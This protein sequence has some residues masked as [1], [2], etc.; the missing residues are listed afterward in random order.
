MSGFIGKGDL[1]DGEPAGVGEGRCGDRGRCHR[2]VRQVERG[3]EAVDTWA[4]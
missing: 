3:L 2:Q 4:S 1:G